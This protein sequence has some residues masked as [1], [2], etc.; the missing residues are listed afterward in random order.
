M[1]LIQLQKVLLS[2]QYTLIGKNR[3]F[4]DGSG[5]CF[6]LYFGGPAER[7]PDRY[8]QCRIDK[9]YPDKNGSQIVELEGY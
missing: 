7:I 6:D 8:L 1:L 4:A 5:E 3:S 2:N 9:V